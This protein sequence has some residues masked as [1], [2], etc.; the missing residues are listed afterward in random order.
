MRVP[1][2]EKIKNFVTSV[3]LITVF[4]AFHLTFINFIQHECL[5]EFLIDHAI[6][7]HL[8]RT[9]YLTSQFYF[10]CCAK[11]NEEI[12]KITCTSSI[13]G[14]LF[15]ILLNQFIFIFQTFCFFFLEYKSK[16][17]CLWNSEKCPRWGRR[18]VRLYNSSFHILGNKENANLK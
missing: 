17:W 11:F 6:R 3:C 1:Q 9:I 15:S 12:V 10:F 7:K 4:V 5:H 13:N 2:I 8:I 14:L 16:V 18:T